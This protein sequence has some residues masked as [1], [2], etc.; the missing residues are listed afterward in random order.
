MPCFVTKIVVYVCNVTRNCNNL[1][2]IQFL[3]VLFC[4]Y[5][6]WTNLLCSI[7]L[8]GNTIY[9]SNIIILPFI[10]QMSLSLIH[11]VNLLRITNCNEL[12]S[13]VQEFCQHYCFKTV[14]AVVVVV[15]EGNSHLIRYDLVMLN[16][17]G[18]IYSPY[19]AASRA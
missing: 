11:T 5:N 19:T 14:A 4:Y 17:P 18:T 16:N 7:H 2:V 9:F 10:F 8:F 1:I 13:I 12:H 15:S 6:L 3:S